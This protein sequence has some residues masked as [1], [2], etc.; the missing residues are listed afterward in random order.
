MYRKCETLVWKIG[1]IFVGFAGGNWNEKRDI[2]CLVDG[3]I[4]FVE[5]LFT[6]NKL[7]GKLLIIMEEERKKEA[8]HIGIPNTY[9]EYYSHVD[10]VMVGST[11]AHTTTIVGF[12]WNNNIKM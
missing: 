7:E 1:G 9:S 6:T 3:E 2:I 12:R 10:D 8:F 4:V 5:M 11:Y